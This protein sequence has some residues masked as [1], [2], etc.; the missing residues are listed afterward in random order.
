MSEVGIGRVGVHLVCASL[1]MMG[2]SASIVEQEGFDVVA[3]YKGQVLRIEVKATS[4][5]I[6]NMQRYSFMT[7]KGGKK[8]IISESDCDLVALVDN[9]GRRCYYMPAKDVIRMKTSLYNHHF[10]DEFLLFTN[11][12]KKLNE[13]DTNELG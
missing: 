4:V 8:R 11:A 1:E 13:E 10:K 3:V 2:V 5:A 9:G 6:G 12:V 7:A